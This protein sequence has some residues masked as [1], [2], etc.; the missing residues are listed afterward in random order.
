MRGGTGKE[1]LRCAEEGE[2]APFA[3]ETGEA[4]IEFIAVMV[5]FVIPVFYIILSLGQLQAATYAAEA[6]ARNAARIL[7]A[8]PHS[9]ALAER[10]AQLAF[11]DFGLPDPAVTA[12]CQPTNCSTNG[13]VSVVVEAHTPLPLLPDWVGARATFPVVAQ[14][15]MPVEGLSV[16]GL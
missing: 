10:Q 12:A 4:L 16:D 14:V 3:A 13:V 8:N 5:L 1:T 11:S 9:Y 7:A 6:A 2:D 15:S